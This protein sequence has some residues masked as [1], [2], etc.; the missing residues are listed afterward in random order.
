MVVGSRPLVS[1][2]ITCEVVQND[3]SFTE[4]KITNLKLSYILSKS[5]G[6]D[7]RNLLSDDPERCVDPESS[8]DNEMRIKTLSIKLT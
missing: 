5:K 1:S 8:T 4:S 7:E 2:A 3:F 6:S